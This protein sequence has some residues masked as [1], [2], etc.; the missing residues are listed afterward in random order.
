[1]FYALVL[2][3][4]A[5][6]FLPHPPNVACVCALSLFAGCYLQGRKAYLVP[7]SVL[8]LSDMIGQL[9]GIPGKGFY[10]AAPMIAVYGGAL[11][12]IPLGRLLR[13][14][15]KWWKVPAASVTASTAFFLISNFGVWLGPWYP[16]TGAGL[17]ACYAN[18]IPFYG[19]TLAGDLVYTTLLFGAWQFGPAAL[20][21]PAPSLARS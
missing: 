12:A 19:Y 4:A 13:S 21:M 20:R 16:T 3:V 6:R 2:L 10:T 15:K 18:A 11:A 1:M 9:M 14:D 17:V 5:S 8:L 7:L